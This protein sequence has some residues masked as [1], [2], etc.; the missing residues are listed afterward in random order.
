MSEVQSYVGLGY[1]LE[2]GHLFRL[3]I[4]H[5]QECGYLNAQVCAAA[6]DVQAAVDKFMHPDVTLPARANAVALGQK[7]KAPKTPDLAPAQI[8]TL[9]L[10]GTTIAGLARDTAYKLAVAGFHTT[11]LPPTVHADTPTPS[12]SSN[13][14]Y[15]DAVQ[16]RSKQAAQQLAT[17]MGPNTKLA[18]MPPELASYAQQ[19]SNP[20]TVVVVGTAFGGTLVDPQANIV[21]VPKRQPP[22][23]RSDPSVTENMLRA[24]RSQVAFRI[25]VPTII[26]SGSKLAQLE[27]LR[28][29]RPYPHKKELV[30]TF[31][32]GA[33]NVYWQIIQTDWTT[34]PILRN[35]TRKVTLQGEK[36]ELYTNAIH[37]HMVILRRANT[38][39]WVVNTLRDELSNETML[40][41]AK[42]LQPLGR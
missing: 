18:A 11:S 1:Q 42:G 30:A 14:V 35:P 23:T 12:Y 7:P 28:V 33:D 25:M 40:A 8:T 5:L 39:Y 19:A 27:P 32:T 24:V 31:V 21:D 13:Y 38:S 29:F 36:Y 34:A 16:P 2:P 22:A 9:V 15:Y 41:I 20:L 3:D 6:S 17:V 26:H 10:N 37:I 4:D